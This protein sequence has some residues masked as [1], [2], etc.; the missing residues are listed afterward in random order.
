MLA[1]WQSSSE[2]GNLYFLVYLVYMTFDMKFFYGS[3]LADIS[4]NFYFWRWNWEGIYYCYVQGTL[5]MML[6]LH[7]F[8]AC[9]RLFSLVEL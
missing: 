7:Y 5:F 4:R 6:V 3:S 1:Y 8:V 2:K 9:K